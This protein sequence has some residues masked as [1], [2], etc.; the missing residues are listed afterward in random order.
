MEASIFAII[1]TKSNTVAVK[2]YYSLR[3]LCEDNKFD[4]KIVKDN[5]PFR[6]QDKIV[7]KAELISEM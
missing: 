6:H 4:R 7:V 5:I 2:C 1:E 3:K